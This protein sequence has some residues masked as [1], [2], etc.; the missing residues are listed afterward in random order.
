MFT[1]YLHATATVPPYTQM[2]YHLI[3]YHTVD[4]LLC[5][6]ACIQLGY[7]LLLN[8]QVKESLKTYRKAFNMDDTSLPALGGIIHCQLIEGH[9]TEAEQQLEFLAEVSACLHV[10]RLKKKIAS[11]GLGRRGWLKLVRVTLLNS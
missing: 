9:I 4:V 5:Y 10:D 3:Y 11:P 1:F 8:G 6:H 7:Q 2:L